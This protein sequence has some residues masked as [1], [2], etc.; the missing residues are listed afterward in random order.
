MSANPALLI[1]SSP[2]FLRNVLRLDALSCLACGA[3]QVA[4]PGQM[5]DWLS[6]PQPLIA[7]TGEFLL[8]YAALVLFIS[9]RQPTPRGAVWTLV[10]GNLAWGLACVALLLAPAFQPSPLGMAYVVLQ[11]LTVALMAGLQF[12][13]LRRQAP[14]PA[15]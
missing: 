9:W 2:N 15:W 1:A 13:G 10:A 12:I 6:L 11:A 5:A 4:M 8:A 3:L 14:V 7:W